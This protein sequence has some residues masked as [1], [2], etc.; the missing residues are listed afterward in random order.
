MDAV[1][2]G[3]QYGAREQIPGRHQQGGG[4]QLSRGGEDSQ[5]ERNGP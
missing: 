4:G 3:E 2:R 5:A 1:R